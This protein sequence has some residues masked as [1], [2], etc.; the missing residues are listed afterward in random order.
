[1]SRNSSTSSHDSLAML[2]EGNARFVAG[3]PDGRHRDKA[4]RM[5]TCEHGQS[6]AAILVSCSDSRVPP[7]IIFDSGIGD[8]FVVRVAGNI[9]GVSEMGSIEYAVERL[10][11]P[12]LVVKGHSK[13]GAVR[14]VV[15]QEP[16]KGSL[17]SIAQRIAPAVK[18]IVDRKPE[19]SGDNLVDECSKENVW[20]QIENLF[21]ESAVVR[22]AV[23]LGHVDVIGAYYDLERGDVSWMGKHPN[24]YLLLNAVADFKPEAAAILRV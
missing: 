3:K 15:N 11:V 23:T 14:A 19:L 4:R 22:D 17:L 20:Q 5:E 16:V 21:L 2:K 6:P 13:C 18:K 10:R 9:C 7:E 12:L 24:E 1:M 8:L